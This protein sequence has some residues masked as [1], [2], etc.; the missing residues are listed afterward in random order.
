MDCFLAINDER[1]SDFV[2]DYQT[3]KGRVPSDTVPIGYD[4]GGNLLLLGIGSRNYGQVFFWMQSYEKDGSE[5]GEADYR[6]VGFVANS[7]DEFLDS[8]YDEE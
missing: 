2:S 4:P 8:L 7:F 1:S 3:Y 5:P 6:N